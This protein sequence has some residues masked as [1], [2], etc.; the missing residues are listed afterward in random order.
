MTYFVKLNLLVLFSSHG[1]GHVTSDVTNYLFQSPVVENID[2][3]VVF[4][5]LY[6]TLDADYGTVLAAGPSFLVK[7]IFS[8]IRV[9]LRSR[10]L[11]YIISL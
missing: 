6:L 2:N 4:T 7:E 5:V 9:K 1:L 11:F 8:L 10:D 3:D